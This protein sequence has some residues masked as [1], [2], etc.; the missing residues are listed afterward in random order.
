MANLSRNAPLRFRDDNV[1]RE[2][3]TL[4]NSAA[5]TIYRGHPMIIDASADT[6]NARG[7]L[8]ATTLVSAADVF[9]GIADEPKVVLTTDVEGDNEI[10]I[11]TG[12]EV[13]FKSAVFTDA[14]VGAAVSMTD[15]GTLSGDAAAADTLPIG[16]LVR[17]VDGYAYVRLATPTIVTFV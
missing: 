12:G 5:Q 6:V 10:M 2:L 8:A 16:T 17:V 1:R 15:S 13:G 11:I 9:L 3:W 4:D 14:D 7:W